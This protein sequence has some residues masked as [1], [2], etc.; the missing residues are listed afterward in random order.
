[1]MSTSAWRWR[2]GHCLNRGPK[3][4]RLRLSTACPPTASKRSLF[5]P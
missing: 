2:Q 3:R 5:M 4:V 1:M